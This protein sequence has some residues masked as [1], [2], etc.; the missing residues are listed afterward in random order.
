MFIIF[1]CE[2][3]GA[4]KQLWRQWGRDPVLRWGPGRPP[5]AAPPLTRLVGG[6]PAVHKGAPTHRPGQEQDIHPTMCTISQA[7]DNNLDMI[8]I[9][10]TLQTRK[11]RLALV[12]LTSK[13]AQ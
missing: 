11:L 7:F 3:G 8:F 10:P 2:G 13:D 4:E 12:K 9:I 5:P 1:T 6:G